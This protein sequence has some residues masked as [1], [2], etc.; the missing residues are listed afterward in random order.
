MA[1]RVIPT[2]APDSSLPIN[3]ERLGEFVRFKRTSLD[4][5]IEN[6]ASLCGVSKQAFHNLELGL[7]SVKLA[8]VFK[9][10]NNL[11]IS[12]WFDNKVAENTQEDNDDW[13]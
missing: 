2:E 8:T 1:K 5:S 11:G 10:L 9:I 12:L 4:L 7:E 13:L 3:M 6:A